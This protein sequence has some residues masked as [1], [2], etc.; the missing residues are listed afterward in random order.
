MHGT[1]VV[2]TGASSGIGL[3][4]AIGMAALGAT[5]VLA[6][7]D[8]GKAE[9]AAADVRAAATGGEVHVVDLDL[10]DLPSV[11]ACADELL[12]R[13]ERID[14]LINNAGGIWSPRRVTRQGLEMTFGVNH[15]GHFALTSLLAERLRASSPSRVV[16]VSSVAHWFA[17]GGMRFDDLQSEG[18]YI[19]FDAY[20]RSKLAN[21]LFTREL[22]RRLAGT[23]VTANAV[24]PG[25]VRS[26]FGMDGDLGGISG[27][28]NHLMRP[29]EITPE[30]G[31][32][33]SIHV[34]TAPELSTTTGGYFARSRPA[35][36]A[37]WARDDGAATRLW[38]MSHRIAARAG[39]DL[40]DVVAAPH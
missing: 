27:L 35:R 25:P 4:T 10:A 3:H 7:R 39:L 2:I 13:F 26:G 28:G 24:H 15:L 14:V 9:A 20:A 1:T 36:T 12:A 22:A 6:C 5:T 8:R 11:R 31:A 19:G 38:D 17:P 29:F 16:T 18:R 33:T 34:A 40:P 21:I 23:G 32:R 37:P 30:A